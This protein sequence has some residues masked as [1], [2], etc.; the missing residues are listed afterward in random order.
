MKVRYCLNGKQIVKI[1]K[2]HITRPS[3]L[4][5]TLLV[6]TESVQGFY[7]CI[8]WKKWR[9]GRVTQMPDSQT[10]EYSATQG[11]RSCTGARV[12]PA[13]KLGLRRK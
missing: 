3:K 4:C 13:E 10:T 1:K 8:Y 7:A 11:G 6:G 5:V 12:A 2:K 9:F